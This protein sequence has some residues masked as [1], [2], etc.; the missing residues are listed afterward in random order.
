MTDSYLFNRNKVVV[1]ERIDLSGNIQKQIEGTLIFGVQVWKMLRILA[2]KCCRT[3]SRP[4]L[5]AGTLNM[6]SWT[7]K[8]PCSCLDGFPV[9]RDGTQTVFHETTVAEYEKVVLA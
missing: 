5:Y 7:P 6:C 8:F 9:F 4:A 3:Y 1:G 2:V